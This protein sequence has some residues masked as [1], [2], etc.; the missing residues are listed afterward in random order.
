MQQYIK[1]IYYFIFIRSSTCF[2][3]YTA[4]YQEPKTALAASGFSY[5]RG[6]WTCRW[7]TLSGT[8]PVPDDVHHLHVQKPLTYENPE[9]ASAVLGS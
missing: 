5:V 7:W 4:H 1:I 2:G 9:A 6:F 8:V 3:R